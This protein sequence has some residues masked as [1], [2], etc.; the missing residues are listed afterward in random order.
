MLVG[1]QKSDSHS[2]AKI[3]RYTVATGGP[4]VTVKPI[5]RSWSRA[6]FL[7]LSGLSRV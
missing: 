3:H 5:L 7:A 1:I 4:R 2:D 6:R